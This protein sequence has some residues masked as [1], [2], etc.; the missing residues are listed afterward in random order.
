MSLGLLVI[1][2]VEEPLASSP[3]TTC[4]SQID[5]NHSCAAKS[6]P[7]NDLTKLNPVVHV[8]YKYVDEISELTNSST[9]CR[10]SNDSKAVAG[11]N[12]LDDPARKTVEARYSEYLQA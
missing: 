9:R 1:V 6:N 10:R 2:F 8:T 7:G 5:F 3:S 11:V 4:L 12:P